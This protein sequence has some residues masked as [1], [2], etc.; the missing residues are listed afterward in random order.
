SHGSGLYVLPHVARGAVHVVPESGGFDAVE[1]L[2]L[3]D[4]WD[5]A[6]MFAAPTMVKR[7]ITALSRT[8]IGR[9]KCIVYGGGP[10]YIEDCKAAFAALGPRLAQ[11]YGQGETPMTITAMDRATLAD[12]LARGDEAR[13]ASVGIAQTGIEIRIGDP[14]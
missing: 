7:L 4:R 11:I 13:I 6:L 8:P 2:A 5:R 3:L 12:A 10:M 14:S 1:T 9:L